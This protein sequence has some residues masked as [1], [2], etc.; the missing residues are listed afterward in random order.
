MNT[1]RIS[2]RVRAPDL[3]TMPSEST[4]VSSNTYDGLG[5]KPG[6]L[7]QPGQ[8]KPDIDKDGMDKFVRRKLPFIISTFNPRTLASTAKKEE[9]VHEAQHYSIDIIC[10]QEH[11][12]VHSQ[13]LLQEKFKGYT[14]ITSSA[15]KNNRNA[16][17][18][19]VG[20]LLSPR[21]LKAC[22]SIEKCSDRIMK[23][24][25]NGNPETTVVCCYSPHNEHPEE[26][27]THFYQELSTIINAIPAHNF[28]LICG[29]F[30]AQL[31]ATDSL[32]TYS[33]NTNRNGKHM[34]D[35]MEQFSLIATN[36][37]FQNRTSKLWT[38]RRPT[39][40]FAQLD[41]VLAR[42]KWI[43][44]IKNSRAYNTFEGVD[45]DHRIVS[46]KCQISY[47][48]SKAPAKD[49]MKGIDWKK[50]V[51]DVNLCEQY[52]V[53]VHNRFSTLCDELNNDDSSA[54]YDTL[55]TAN[56]TI[57]LEMLPKR[58]KKS[59]AFASCDKVIKARVDLKKAAQKHH[60][61]STRST[62][63]NLEEAKVTLDEA[64]TEVL[65]AH[66][67]TKTEELDRLHHE[68][69]HAAAWE[70][71]RELTNK[72]ASPVIRI[73]GG[74][75]DQRLDTWFQHFSSLLGKQEQTNVILD[76]PFFNHK[77][78][79]S[80]PIKIC[81]F[82]MEELQ[83]CLKK[84]KNSKTA[85]PDNIPA[86][87]WKSTL[88]HEQLLKFC[89]ETYMGNKP[90]AFSKSSIIPLPKKGDLQLP[91]N[92]RGIT[93]SPLASKVYNS[94]LL[95]RISPHLDPILRRNQNGFR[96]GRST[97]PQILAIRRIIE[98]LKISKRK[99][100]IIF[101]DFSKAF[102][103]VNR[104][105][106][107]HILLNYGIPEEIVKAIAIMYDNPTSF[108]QSMDGPTKEFLT[109][110][111]ILQGDTLAPY[112]F[113]IVVDYILRQ[114]LDT[115]NHKGLTIKPRQ[116][117]RQKG[118]HLTDLDYADDLALTADQLHNAQELL[119]SLEDAAAKVGLFLNSKKTEYMTVNEAENHQSI[120]SI[121]GTQLKEVSD[122]KYLGSFVV[123]SKK[124]FMSRKGQAW[125]AC[126]KLHYIWQSGISKS[127]KLAFFRACVE[128]ILLY[129][130]E[131]WTMKKELQDRLDGTYTRLLMRVQNISWREHK[132]KM[133]IYGDIPP[134][135]TI[136]A[137]RR[138]RFA[139]HC[140]RAKNQVISDV[141][142]WRLPCPNR[143]RRP[144][145]YIDVI[146]RDIQQ[147]TEDMPNLMSNKDTWRCAVNSISVATA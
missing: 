135:S 84:L 36:T 65:K 67:E 98:E 49:P 46:C 140:F 68:N 109:T 14:L 38:H 142:C 56:R 83:V 97:L 55:T 81:L 77:V 28:L 137:Q 73:K 91:Q 33:K 111:G 22:C 26:Y 60:T 69:K 93:L 64:Y 58:R 32:F 23:A 118:K 92:Y 125:N 30:N 74:T 8:S 50:V 79:D 34:K 139:G 94:M 4:L 80:L 35:F 106:M 9:L 131:T 44:S 122:F 143:G 128:S 18:G 62:K 96:K 113:V 48:Q 105:V 107:L 63:R 99:A 76:E 17:T 10:L 24:T 117:S 124:D 147:E 71:V 5:L 39:G 75:K 121:N 90:V 120:C 70:V 146:A 42:K 86:V 123:D 108:V 119:L 133:Y 72:K 43:N 100:S 145:N 89:N 144:F 37:R 47:R 25:L 112:L 138:A 115:I 19:G 61:K 95:N 16:A 3:M 20:L 129:G 136:V 116:S 114:S 13:S 52:T 141:I 88:F 2:T 45:S 134:V 6:G 59:I 132:T 127:T 40:K 101:V 102:D 53:A 78:V 126:N 87:I 51:A 66:V 103:S 1:Q 31:G 130:A 54:V 82:S 29:D 104:K 12:N 15:W 7:K 21:A 41:Y 27:V 57:A 85:G 11:R 110:A